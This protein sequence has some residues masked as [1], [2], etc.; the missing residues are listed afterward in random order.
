MKSLYRNTENIETQYNLCH[1]GEVL[2]TI[3][4]AGVFFISFGFFV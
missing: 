1:D 3:I 4:I 2:L